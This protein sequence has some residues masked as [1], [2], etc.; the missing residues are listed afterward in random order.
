MTLILTQSINTNIKSNTAKNQGHLKH[1]FGE[2]S[3]DRQ[4][5]LNVTCILY[6]RFHSVIKITNF[7]SFNKT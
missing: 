4:R 7:R 3:P 1:R 6:G 5:Y 2:F